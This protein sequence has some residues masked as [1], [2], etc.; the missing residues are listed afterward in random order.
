MIIKVA[1]SLGNTM[2]DFVLSK[3]M[4]EESHV[5]CVHRSLMRFY[6]LVIW[7]DWQVV[8]RIDDGEITVIL[9]VCLCLCSF[10]AMLTWYPPTKIGRKASVCEVSLK[11]FAHKSFLYLHL[12]FVNVGLGKEKS[13][14]NTRTTDLSGQ[15]TEPTSSTSIWRPVLNRPLASLVDGEKRLPLNQLNSDFCAWTARMFRWDASFVVVVLSHTCMRERSVTKL[16]FW[17]VKCARIQWYSR[18]L[19]RRRF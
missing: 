7:N 12:P 6:L 19:R 3:I 18:W 8:T 2:S 15:T 17:L 5:E 4:L 9:I 11:L 13:W 1:N 16:N 14:P 10:E